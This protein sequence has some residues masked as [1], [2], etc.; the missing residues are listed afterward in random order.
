MFG[1]FYPFL[2]HKNIISR[3][4]FTQTILHMKK[5][6][7]SSLLT[8]SLSAALVICSVLMPLP[9]TSESTAVAEQALQEEHSPALKVTLLGTGSP[10]LSMERFGPATVRTSKN[11]EGSVVVGEDLMSFEIGNTVKV[12]EPRFGLTN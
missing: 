4:R 3:C 10:L 6:R 2:L 11:Y 12:K 8:V 9:W 5:T 7:F 1:F